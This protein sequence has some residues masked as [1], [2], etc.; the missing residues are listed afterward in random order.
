MIF[1]VGTKLG[2]A[3]IAI[4]VFT[5]ISVVT[6]IWS[7]E[8]FARKGRA[9]AAA[10][11][12][13]HDLQ[14]LQLLFQQLLMPANDF[15]VHGNAQER[16]I[17]DQLLRQTHEQL[18]RCRKV[19]RTKTWLAKLE[20]FS[21]HLA[22]L[23]KQSRQIFNLPNP[24]TNP[25]GA[26]MMEQMDARADDAISHLRALVNRSR[27]NVR[28]DVAAT[29]AARRVGFWVILLSGL[30]SLMCA[31][32]SWRILSQNL[33]VRL[34]RVAKATRTIATGTSVPEL[35]QDSQ[36]EI[37][38]LAAAFNSMVV[39]LRE[40]TVSRRY[41]DDLIQSLSEALV[42]VDD[43]GLIRTSNQ[44]AAALTGK[45]D[46][47]L[48][49]QSFE[50]LFK[51]ASVATTFLELA[52]RRGQVTDYEADWVG[53][54]G[55]SVPVLLG[56]TRIFAPQ[57]QS[58][59]IVVVAGD[60]TGVR[61]D[62]DLRVERASLTAVQELITTYHHQLN[63]PLMVGYLLLDEL[64]AYSGDPERIQGSLEALQQ[65]LNQLRSP[66]EALGRI[67]ELERTPY[68]GKMKMLKVP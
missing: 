38:E 33:T 41:L 56:G 42:V 62:E 45:P 11:K 44:A 22:R 14:E 2:F 52:H 67:K 35:V 47:A 34:A 4:C 68:V 10:E 5:A 51:K 63:Q 66:L 18:R 37:G 49:D 1:K 24:R 9:A 46:G 32:V 50:A 13:H 23:E 59:E 55:K 21:G 40:S 25:R 16:A 54:D 64:R 31:L 27:E 53:P 61:L 57:R 29:Q 36:D 39:E 58:E 65:V 12:Q 60:L 19:A 26:K 7:L 43:K 20:H 15:L 48:Q 8:H 17:F 28:K 6:A 30:M 3:F